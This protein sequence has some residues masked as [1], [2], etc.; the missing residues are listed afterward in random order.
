MAMCARQACHAR[1]T[2]RE[3]DVIVPIDLLDQLQD[4][5]TVIVVQ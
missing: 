3:E 5:I 2:E 1:V 4:G